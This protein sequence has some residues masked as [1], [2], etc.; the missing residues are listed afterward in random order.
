DP[1]MCCPLSRGFSSRIA[2]LSAAQQSSTRTPPAALANDN[3]WSHGGHNFKFGADYRRQQFNHLSQ[4]DARGA[5]TFAGA[6]T[7]SDFA[8]FLL[9]IP[10]TSSIAFG[11]ADKYFRASS[12]AAYFTDDWRISPALTLNAGVRWEYGSPITELYGRLVNLDIGP[13]FTAEA[14]VVSARPVGVLTGQ[15]Y[16]DSLVQ[17]DRHGFQPRVGIAWRPFPA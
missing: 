12:Y 11:N 1:V 13:R 4:Q 14:P 8:G 17:P 10:D 5:F 2:G 3:F 6:V 16:P 15:K 9:G 7:G